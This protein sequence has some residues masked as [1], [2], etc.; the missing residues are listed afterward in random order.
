MIQLAK[1]QS[2][3]KGVF[4]FA[5]TQAHLRPHAPRAARLRKLYSFTATLQ[6]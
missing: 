1:A 2:P 4:P 5:A 6:K 3:E